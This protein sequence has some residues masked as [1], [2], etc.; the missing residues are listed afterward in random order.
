MQ[1]SERGIAEYQKQGALG[2]SCDLIR[3]RAFLIQIM[4]Y[5]FPRSFVRF[6]KIFKNHWENIIILLIVELIFENS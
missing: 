3:T 2:S 6:W 5:F 1:N 4:I